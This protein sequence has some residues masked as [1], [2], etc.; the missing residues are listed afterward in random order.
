MYFPTLGADLASFL[1]TLAAVQ[2]GDGNYFSIGGPPTQSFPLAP[3]LLGQ[4]R[5]LSNSH[6][7]FEADASPAR[8]DLYQFGEAY[9]TQL[10]F[11]QTMYDAPG[12]TTAN[13]DPNY[14]LDLLGNVAVTRSQQSVAQNP[15]Y[16]RGFVAFFIPPGTQAFIF[17]LFGNK[18][19][20]NPEGSL[21]R[22]TLKSFYAISGEEPNLTYSPGG[23]RI[24]ENW[25]KRALSDPYTV[26][27]FA[28]DV[29]ALIQQHPVLANF[30]G[31]TGEVNS[32]AGLDISN[33]TV[34]CAPYTTYI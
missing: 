17:R 31:N 4:P 7:R 24:P 18:S 34:C 11:F 29:L 23:E 2:T 12:T 21:D 9:L 33:V 30:G 5:G 8:G 26:P 20:E 1:A 3:G 13:P 6:N 10:P 15:Y 22:A 32:F 19:A 28:S 27:L 25:Y 14:D 16:F